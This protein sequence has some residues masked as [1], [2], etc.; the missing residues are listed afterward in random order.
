MYESFFQLMQRPFAAAPS[1]DR[2]FPVGAVEASRQ[3]L[4]RSIERAEGAALL[5]GPAG[6]GKTLL[7][8]LLAEN[9]RGPYAVALLSNGHLDTRRELLQAILFELGLPYRRLEE[10]ELRLSLIDYVSNEQNARHGL[11]LLVDEAHTLTPRLLEEVRLIANLVR[12]GQP[13]V[14]LVLAGNPSLEEMLADPLLE[15]LSQRVATRRYL[16]ALDYSQTQQFIVAQLAAPRGGAQAI[17]TPDALEAVYR[18][19]D[20]VPRLINQVCDHALTLAFAGGAQQI[21]RAGVEEAWA[22]LQQLPTPWNVAARPGA[23]RE[24]ARE[25]FIE[26]GSLDDEAELATEDSYLDDSDF[27]PAAEPGPEA[28]ATLLIHQIDDHLRELDRDFAASTTDY[29]YQPA[30]RGARDPFGEHFEEEEVL[31]D[32]YCTLEPGAITDQQQVECDESRSLSALLEPCLP[33]N[34]PEL[35]ALDEPVA[36]NTQSIVAASAAEQPWF[37]TASIGSLAPYSAS[38]YDA[39]ASPWG[40]LP[41]PSLGSD[42]QGRPPHDA[43]EGRREVA[44]AEDELEEAAAIPLVRNDDWAIGADDDLMVVEDDPRAER[45]TPS[46]TR[47]PQVRRQE[48][49]QLFSSLRRG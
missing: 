34:L 1:V 23:T 39:V 22:D 9:F 21:D 33:A 24:A 38:T 28:E 14:R 30:D 42:G 18:A 46:L 43:D 5:V 26:F 41:K 3:A 31:V 20:G 37:Q 7:C 15:A 32:R 29:L 49:R 19:T 25:G 35:D 36:E 13:R 4:V 10:G 6:T 47:T 8:H 17:F 27:A 40:G 12:H 44:V 11:L 16:E 48:Y 2:Y 45:H